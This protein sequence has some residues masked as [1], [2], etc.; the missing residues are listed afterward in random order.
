MVDD[1]LYYRH[2][3]EVGGLFTPD[4]RFIYLGR[5]ESIV[6]RTQLPT[7]NFQSNIQGMNGGRIYRL[8]EDYKYDYEIVIIT[9]KG[10]RVY[11]AKTRPEWAYN[12]GLPPVGDAAYDVPL[13]ACCTDRIVLQLR[14]GR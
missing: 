1:A 12:P 10:D 11:F 8:P 3:T 6:P 9:P 14:L 5:V 4:D 13:P 7:E 2:S